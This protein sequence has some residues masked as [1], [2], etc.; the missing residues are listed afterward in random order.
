MIAPGDGDGFLSSILPAEGLEAKFDLGLAWSNERG[1]TLR[2]AGSLDATL[3]VNLSIRDVLRI[4][5]LHLGLQASDAGLSAE[6]SAAV[7][8]SLGP[9]N[10]VVDRGRHQ[11]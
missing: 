6:V 7:G 10:A 11:K 8:L 2:G 9:V 1:L 5:T 3:P 4:P